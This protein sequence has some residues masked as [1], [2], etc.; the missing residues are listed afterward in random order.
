MSLRKY[1]HFLRD[2]SNFLKKEVKRIDNL[3]KIEKTNFE[4]DIEM[5][6]TSRFPVENS[7]SDPVRPG[8]LIRKIMKFVRDNRHAHW[9][10]L[11]FKETVQFPLEVYFREE[12]AVPKTQDVAILKR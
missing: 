1:V 7:L 12:T 5:K 4:S 11:S 3:D 6:M 9:Q 10:F 2:F 8:D